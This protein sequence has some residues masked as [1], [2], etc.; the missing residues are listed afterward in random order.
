M[1]CKENKLN[2][3]FIHKSFFCVRLSVCLAKEDTWLFL[4]IICEDYFY[5]VVD[6][7]NQLVESFVRSYNT[8]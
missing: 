5:L 4:L 1:S 3:L 2:N 7:Y 6:Y 8:Q